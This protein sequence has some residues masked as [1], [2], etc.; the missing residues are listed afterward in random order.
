ML[1]VDSV[2]MGSID[3]DYFSTGVGVTGHV[4]QEHNHA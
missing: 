1:A 2:G 3:G 4:R